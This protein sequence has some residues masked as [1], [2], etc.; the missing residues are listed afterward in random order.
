MLPFNSGI[1][2]FRKGTPADAELL[3][4]IGWRTF[5]EAFGVFNKPEDMEAFR[6]TM[7]SPELQATELTDPEVE[8]VIVEVDSETVGYM[9]LRTGKA[10]DVIAANKPLHINRL[11]VVKKWL[12]RGLGNKMIDFCLEKARQNGHDVIWLTVWE[13]NERAKRFYK[14]H[15]FEEVGELD[16]VLGNDVQRDLYLR[17][18]VQGQQNPS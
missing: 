12:G 2:H 16:F 10:P 9:M 4:E 11:Y 6:P 8:F 7:Y 13:R 3:A 14:K 18:E 1:Y 15:Q 17:R 5:D